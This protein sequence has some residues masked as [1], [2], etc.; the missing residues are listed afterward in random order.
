M[1]GL[2]LQTGGEFASS[3]A[4]AAKCDG[5]SPGCKDAAEFHWQP[6]SRSTTISIT[7]AHLYRRNTIKQRRAA[8]AERHEL[9]A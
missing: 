4:T 8:L 9:A 7:R 6:T 3:D 1:W 2:T 5:A